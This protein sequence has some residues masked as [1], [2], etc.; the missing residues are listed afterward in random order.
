ML[1]SLLLLVFGV[2]AQ[3]KVQRL[4]LDEAMQRALKNRYD[5]KIQQVNVNI[6]VNEISK[7]TARNLPQLT[8]DLDLRYNNQLQTNV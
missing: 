5:V 7:V 4:S 8:S 2:N 1:L 3:E 6:S